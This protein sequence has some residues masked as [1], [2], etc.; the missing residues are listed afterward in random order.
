MPP[1]LRIYKTISDTVAKR[2]PGFEQI[3][4][5]MFDYKKAAMMR[6]EETPIMDFLV[7][8]KIRASFGGRLR[9]MFSGRLLIYH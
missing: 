8:R 2:G 5:F 3:F 9:F 6:G 4:Q 1:L 7:F